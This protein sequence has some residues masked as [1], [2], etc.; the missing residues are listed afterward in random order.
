MAKQTNGE[1][2]II[3]S[4]PRSDE[5]RANGPPERRGVFN[6]HIAKCP[7]CGKES[8][9]NPKLIGRGWE[10]YSHQDLASEANPP[11]EEEIQAGKDYEARYK[12]YEQALRNLAELQRKVNRNYFRNSAG[13]REF[14]N[15]K[16]GEEKAELIREAEAQ[17][18]E[19]YDRLG[20][21]QRRRG[22]L[23][24]AR[25]RRLQAFRLEQARK[26]SEAAEKARKEAKGKRENRGHFAARIREIL[27]T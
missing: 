17:I 12:E 1:M 6:K 10:Q 19:A 20:E 11:T 22:S 18:A 9:V 27:R 15:K 21:A 7:F 8:P 5:E 4:E 25:S 24:Q 13:D 14:R 23:D 3:Y 2:T 26:D 16:L